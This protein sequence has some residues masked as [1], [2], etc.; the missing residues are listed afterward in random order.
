[1]RNVASP[2]YPPDDQRKPLL[3][4]LNAGVGMRPAHVYHMD[5]APTTLALMGVHSN[6]RF[7]AG[8]NRGAADSRG[9]RFRQVRW[10]K[11]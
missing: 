8:A 9:H 4:V 3:F 2:L 1:M 10:R 6:V 11:P 5:I 7:M